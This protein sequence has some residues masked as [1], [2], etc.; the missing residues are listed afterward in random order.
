MDTTPTTV[1]GAVHLYVPI[2]TKNYRGFR[3]KLLRKSDW[4]R[5]D[6]GANTDAAL[7]ARFYM[8]YIKQ[9]FGAAQNGAKN[10]LGVNCLVLQN[11]TVNYPLSVWEG[12]IE[13]KITVDGA[14]LFSFDTSIAILDLRVGIC[15]ND[16][17]SVANVCAALRVTNAPLSY[18]AVSSAASADEITPA[19]ITVNDIAAALLSGVR[20]YTLFDHIGSGAETRADVFSAIIADEGIA[21]KDLNLYRIAAGIDTRG[22]TDVPTDTLFTPFPHLRWAV[23]GKG[24]CSLGLLTTDERNRDFIENNWISIA[25]KRHALWYVLVLHQKYA[26]YRYLNDIADKNSL[27]ALKEAQK[28]I[29][30]FNTRYR[31]EVVSEDTTYQTLYTMARSAKLVESVFSDIDEEIERINDYNDTVSDKNNVI[32]MTIVSLVCAISTFIDIFQFSV[33]GTSITEFVKSLSLP[34]IS[35]FAVVAL[36]IFVSVAFLVIKPLVKWLGAKIRK[37]FSYIYSALFLR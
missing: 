17:K 31:F 29:V 34:Q 26:M 14:R 5:A 33:E 23:T 19:T 18:N 9:I 22:D 6:I 12:D 28:N 30:F 37:L 21:D 8:R 11:D 36:A 2:H 32:A 4:T 15:A 35:L 3:T 16:L 10:P 27:G 7:D 13:H 24:A 20:G 1:R 25:E